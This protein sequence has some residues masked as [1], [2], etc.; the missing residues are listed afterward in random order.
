LVRPGSGLDGRALAVFAEAAGP[1]AAG[2]ALPWTL[3]DGTM[4]VRVASSTWAAELSLRRGELISRLAAELGT[5][6]VRDLRFVV[7]PLDR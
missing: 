2:R 7:A 6:R 4:T 5:D 3:H 1:A